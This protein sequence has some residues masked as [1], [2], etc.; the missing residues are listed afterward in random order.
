MKKET[1]KQTFTFTVSVWL[2]PGETASWHFVTV[3]KKIS[4]VIKKSFGNLAR[5]WGSL[6]VKVFIG[7]TTWRTSIFPDNKMGTYLLPLKKS[8]R[9]AEDVH[10][11]DAVSVVMTV[12]PKF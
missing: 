9:T 12:L 5:G 11:G 1:T 3:P 10:A 2:Y 7:E 4:S 8:V 6:P